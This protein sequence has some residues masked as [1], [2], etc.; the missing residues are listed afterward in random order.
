MSQ[1]T[2]SWRTDDFAFD[3]PPERIAQTATEP[4]DAARLLHVA[5]KTLRDHHVRDLPDLL[6]AGDVLVVN[7]TRVI[8]ARL[9][10]LRGAV[11]VEVLLHKKTA[12]ST[13]RAFAR[14]GKRLHPG[15][16]I[17]F[18]DDLSATVEAK[19]EAG[20]ITVRFAVDDATLLSL[21]VQYGEPPLPPYIHRDAGRDPGQIQADAARYQTVYAQHDGS[22]A[23]PT[24]GLHFTPEL[25]ARLAAKDIVMERVTLHVGAGT[26]LPVKVEKLADHV[27]HSEWGHIPAD[28]AERLN[29][30]KKDG[31]R[32][33]AVGTTALRV[34]ESAANEA[35]ILMP[36]NQETA[37]FIYPGYHFRVVDAL[38]TNFHLPQSTLFMLV[39]AFA[40]MDVMRA[41]YDYALANTYRFYSFGDASLL[42]RG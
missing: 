32:I 18:A 40:G 23:A 9:Y 3:L 21:L 31:R 34:L 41:A 2:T 26:F 42:E 6:R 25:I 19:H 1:H 35:G 17:H 29:Q 12:P 37:I 28:V 14:P 20:D 24:A 7:D 30:Y 5:G 16:V 8:P 4:R 13:W 38:M 10:G 15:D 27:M 33:V 36:F 11:K 22:V 39:C